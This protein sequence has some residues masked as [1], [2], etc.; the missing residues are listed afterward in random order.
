MT[1]QATNHTICPKCSARLRHDV[2]MGRADHP[3]GDARQL[4]NPGMSCWRCGYWKNEQITPVLPFDKKMINSSGSGHPN[5]QK[6][7]DLGRYELVLKHF[8]S[9]NKMRRPGRSQASWSTITQIIRQA[10]G[11]RIKP[12]TLRHH[13]NIICKQQREGVLE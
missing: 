6:N 1:A 8:S 3:G 11:T 10:T 7:N 5:Q 4:F 12:D 13:Y 9:I 2:V